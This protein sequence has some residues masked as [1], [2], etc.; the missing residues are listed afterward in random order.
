LAFAGGLPA[1]FFEEVSSLSHI[2]VLRDINPCMDVSAAKQQFR[3][4]RIWTRL[5]A[6]RANHRMSLVKHDE[7]YRR[8]NPPSFKRI[9]SRRR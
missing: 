1:T 3:R 4:E 6:R 8:R 7:K 2:P 9:I 5:C